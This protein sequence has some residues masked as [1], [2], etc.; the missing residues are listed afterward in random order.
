MDGYLHGELDPITGQT[1]G[2][3][4]RGCRNCEQAYRLSRRSSQDKRRTVESASEILA[5]A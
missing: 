2:Q 4:L 1:I 5:D 3:D